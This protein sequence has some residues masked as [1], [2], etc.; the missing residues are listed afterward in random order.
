MVAERLYLFKS[1]QI[2]DGSNDEYY[3]KKLSEKEL[4]YEPYAADDIIS[5]LPEGMLNEGWYRGRDLI[6]IFCQNFVNMK[7]DRENVTPPLNLQKI[8]SGLEAL[9]LG[10]Y[11][12][13]EVL[14]KINGISYERN[15][16]LGDIHYNT[17][18]K[19]LIE[20]EYI[21]NKIPKINVHTEKDPITIKIVDLPETWTELKDYEQLMLIFKL[22]KATS[23]DKAMNIT[24]LYPKFERVISRFIDNELLLEGEKNGTYFLPQ[25][26]LDIGIEAGIK[27]EEESAKLDR[28]LIYS[29]FKD[30]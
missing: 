11:D 14:K 12:I 23:P 1:R 4:L 8:Q 2:G 29:L 26:L 18:L 16:N 22:N 25:S 19:S 9:A 13:G 30:V 24:N 27:K 7:S 6:K 28:N 5:V 20:I 10:E 15:L 17:L 3:V 21:Q